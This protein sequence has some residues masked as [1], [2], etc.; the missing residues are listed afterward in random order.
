[1]HGEAPSSRPTR[2]SAAARP[3]T[4]ALDTCERLGGGRRPARACLKPE[5]GTVTMPVS[6][7]ICMQ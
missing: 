1:M 3:R 5:P 4:T 2:A 7:S 6:S